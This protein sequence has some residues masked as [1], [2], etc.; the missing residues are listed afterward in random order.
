MNRFWEICSALQMKTATRCARLKVSC[1]YHDKNTQQTLRNLA[2]KR[3]IFELF[4]FTTSQN[5]N[6][7]LNEGALFSRETCEK[8]RN[9]GV[10]IDFPDEQRMDRRTDCTS[11]SISWVNYKMLHTKR[12]ERPSS[13]WVILKLSPKVLVLLEAFFALLM[14]RTKK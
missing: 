2:E 5:L 13:D 9:K 11:V 1:C 8:L 12:A 7:I 3:K 10:K 4:H 14:L 6:S